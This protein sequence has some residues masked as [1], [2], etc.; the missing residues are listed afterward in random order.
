M[1]AATTQVDAALMGVLRTEIN[2]AMA[3][4]AASHGLALSLGSGTYSHDR[5]SGSFKLN[6]AA[7]GDAPAGTSAATLK[8]AAEFKSS[9]HFYG[10]KPEWLGRTFSRAGKTYTVV[11]LMPNRRRFPILCSCNGK[12]VLLVSD[13]VARAL[14]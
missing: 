9:G 12:E 8:A 4:I 10:M 11:G 14:A 7:L 6:I 5:V 3:A 13:D 1:N 2:A